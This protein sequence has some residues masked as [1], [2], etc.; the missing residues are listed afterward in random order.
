MVVVVLLLHHLDCE[1]RMH[2]SWKRRK[3]C[4]SVLVQRE[5]REN[6]RD[7]EQRRSGLR[8]L[9]LET[10]STDGGNDLLRL[11]LNASEF[12]FPL[13]LSFP[14]SRL[15]PLSLVCSLLP[16]PHP[17]ASLIPFWFSLRYNQFPEKSLSMT[18]SLY[19]H[20]HDS[21]S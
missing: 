14:L 4:L 6:L 9:R 7:G 3:C 18:Q 21:S 15:L 11:F 13:F 1:G 2:G 12:S 16:G 10:D 8:Q 17:C 19:N 20:H 5:T